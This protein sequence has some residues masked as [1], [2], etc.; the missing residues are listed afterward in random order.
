MVP[1]FRSSTRLV[2]GAES[3]LTAPKVTPFDGCSR[4]ALNLVC[5]LMDSGKVSTTSLVN[6]S[7]ICTRMGWVGVCVCV[8]VCVCERES[9]LSVCA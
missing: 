5:A 2:L 4:K 3:N 8:C 9:L 1:S 7:K 6:G